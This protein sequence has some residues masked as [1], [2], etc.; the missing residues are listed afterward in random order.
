[1]TPR[2]AETVLKLL[3]ASGGLPE[4]VFSHG[5]TINW[6]FAIVDMAEQA[7]RA[8]GQCQDPDELDEI[9]RLIDTYRK[10]IPHSVY[11]GLSYLWADNAHT[12][13]FRGKI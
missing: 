7:Y 2:P 6:P 10:R 4:Q 11:R 3:E 1:M 13:H 5:Q 12:R 9:G 8:I